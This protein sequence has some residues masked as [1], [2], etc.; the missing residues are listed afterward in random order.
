MFIFAHRKARG[1]LDGEYAAVFRDRSLD[2]DDLRAY[3]PGDEVRDI[4]WKATA[5]HGAPLVRRYIAVR[6]QTVLLVAD[7]GRN[8][9]AV[10]KGGERK[11]DLTVMLLGVLG[12]LALRH[13][14]QV[15]LAHGDSTR[16]WLSAAK[17]GEA[18]LESLLQTVDRATNLASADSELTV[19]LRY[20]AE[21][22]K[23]RMLLVVVADEL[24]A[25]PELAALLRRL[26]AQH[27]VLWLTVEDADLS[28]AASL[29][30]ETLG[31][32]DLQTVAS[33][34]AAEPG[35]AAEYAAAAQ[36]RR[37]EISA[38]LGREGI[39]AQWLGHSEQTM[40]TVFRL[41]EGHRRAGK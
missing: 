20:V 13:G 17:S 26:R 8:M 22:V 2:F 29:G 27:E 37:R 28:D 4:D 31:V 36:T 33:F 10:A 14:D 18:H 1:M 41:L 34:L 12:Y 32:Q 30:A 38:L 19:Q 40:P 39:S 6:K 3:V 35:L 24:A 11:K 25:Q 16:T 15:A 7:T 21:H 23:A 5:R 9:A